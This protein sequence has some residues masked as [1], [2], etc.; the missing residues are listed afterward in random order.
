MQACMDWVVIIFGTQVI[1][2]KPSRFGLCFQTIFPVL[3]TMF[4][5]STIPWC[6]F[7]CM[8]G[9][10]HEHGPNFSCPGIFLFFRKV[11]LFLRYLSFVFLTIPWFTK[12]VMWQWVL[13]YKTGCTFEYI[14]WTT[15]H[16]VTKL[17]QLTDICSGFHFQESFGQLGG[18]GLSSR[19]FSI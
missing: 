3:I 7:R 4:N 1:T 12:P 15:T 17:G 2:K 8:A 5:L 11:I 14:F 16:W 13:L 9:A 6:Y 10:Q 19:S 18:L